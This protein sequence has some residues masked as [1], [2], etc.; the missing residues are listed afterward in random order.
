V[1]V[2][3]PLAAPS[4]APQAD[5]GEPAAGRLYARA[6]GSA[7]RAVV[8]IAIEPGWVLYHSEV[9]GE[10]DEHGN[11]YPGKPLVVRPA[12]SGLAFA[13]ARLPAPHRKHDPQLG[14][15]AWVHEGKIRIYLAAAPGGPPPADLGVS[16]S[17]STCSSKGVCRRYDETLATEG[18][19]PDA[20]F[21]EFPADLEP[22]TSR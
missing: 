16:I 14:N 18:L 1:L 17:G 21:A 11:G 6:D 22:P 8:E 15:W 20:A 7:L 12:G 10:L 19:G 9:G 2:L 13:P 5:P 3:G 4:S